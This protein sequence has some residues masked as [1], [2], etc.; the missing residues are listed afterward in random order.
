[1]RPHT[2]NRFSGPALRLTVMEEFDMVDR[3][4][5]NLILLTSAIAFIGAILIGL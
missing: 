3:L 5:L 2:R 1:M 4:H